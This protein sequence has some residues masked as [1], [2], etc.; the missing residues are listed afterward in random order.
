MHAS[1][2]AKPNAILIS[3]SPAPKQRSNEC[4]VNSF[5]PGASKTQLSTSSAGKTARMRN[6]LMLVSCIT[7]RD[8][9]V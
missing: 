2:A 6:M 1:K 5:P 9:E 3:N 8:K 7:I 4:P